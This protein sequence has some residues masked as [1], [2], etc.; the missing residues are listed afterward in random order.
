VQG[1]YSAGGN[2]TTPL[3]N[4]TACPP[5]F[6]T[7]TSGAKS[8]TECAGACERLRLS[9]VACC[10]CAPMHGAFHLFAST[11]VA[12][13]ITRVHSTVFLP[14]SRALP[15]PACS[16]HRTPCLG[17]RDEGNGGRPHSQPQTRA[18][19]RPNT[20]AHTHHT[21]TH[22]HTHTHAHEARTHSTPITHSRTPRLLAKQLPSLVR[23]ALVVSVARLVPKA[24]TRQAATTPHPWCTAR[25]VLRGTQR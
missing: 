6:T 15:S 13:L 23:P 19:A 8:A 25:L 2:Y 14:M 9:R 3:A 12:R 18:H 1:T 5:R 7:L 22:T 4:C 10:C 11:Q 24:R 16:H 17:L 21:H 20:R